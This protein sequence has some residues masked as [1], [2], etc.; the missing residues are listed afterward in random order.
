MW[1]FTRRCSFIR[2]LKSQ[3][4][5]KVAL[6]NVVSHYENVEVVKPFQEKDSRLLSVIFTKLAYQLGISPVARVSPL[7]SYVYILLSPFHTSYKPIHK[8]AHK[9]KHPH[10]HT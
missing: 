2:M 4:K 10:A 5:H 8:Y 6:E 3:M 7:G 1:E 9:H